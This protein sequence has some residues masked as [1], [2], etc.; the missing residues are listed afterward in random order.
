MDKQA[1]A[2]FDK[3]QEC[4]KELKEKSLRQVQNLR[5]DFSL[6][7]LQNYAHEKL[8]WQESLPT[9]SVMLAGHLYTVDLSQP[10]SCHSDWRTV[11][12]AYD[13]KVEQGERRVALMKAVDHFAQDKTPSL[14]IKQVELL[15]GFFPKPFEKLE[16]IEAAVTQELRLT[17]HVEP[18]EVRKAWRG[19]LYARLVEKEKLAVFAAWTGKRSLKFR[20]PY[21]RLREVTFVMLDLRLGGLFSR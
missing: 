18:I 12:F 8:L 6:K 15:T 20:C 17:L 4:F 19:S 2:C 16:I 11:A 21:E 13:K 5:K 9:L 14:D 1:L 10:L 3:E 7:M